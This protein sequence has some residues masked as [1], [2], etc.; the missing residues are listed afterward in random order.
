MGD[1]DVRAV[2]EETSRGNAIATQRL[3]ARTDDVA[4]DHVVHHASLRS[5]L[6]VLAEQPLRLV[7]LAPLVQQLSKEGVGK[8]RG[9]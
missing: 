9:M 8:P 2:V 5:Q 7:H 6:I 4:G 1:G 3:D